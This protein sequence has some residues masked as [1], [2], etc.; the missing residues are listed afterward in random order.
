M[1]TSDPGERAP[2]RQR[3]MGRRSAGGAEAR[4]PVSHHQAPTRPIVTTE[5]TA[6]DQRHPPKASAIGTA[7][8][9][10]I[11]EPMLIPST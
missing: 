7:S 9:A 11:A 10:E 4:T 3:W 6:S 2:P 5:K 8:A 1:P